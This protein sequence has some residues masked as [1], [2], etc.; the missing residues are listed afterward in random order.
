EA[1]SP[2]VRSRLEM[3]KEISASDYVQ[4]QRERAALRAEVNDLLRHFDALILPTLPIPAPVLGAST[5]RIAGIDEPLR[6]I[7]LRMTQPFNLTGHP[8][9]SLPCGETTDGLPCGF[10]LVGRAQKTRELL[11]IAAAC[12]PMITPTIL[13]H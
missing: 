13:A 9:I 12:E 10:Q 4:A 7:M 3:G 5:A 2:G 1:Y 8:A 11:A 6:P